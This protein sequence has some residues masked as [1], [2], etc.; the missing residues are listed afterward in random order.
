MPSATFASATNADYAFYY[1]SSVTEIVLSA[2]T[3]ASLTSARAMFNYCGLTTALSIDNATFANLADGWGMFSSTNISSLSMAVA[4]F[5]NLTNIQYW[6]QDSKLVTSL[7]MPLATFAKITDSRFAFT[8]CNAL[9]DINVPNIST[10]I[11]QTSNATNTPIDL[12]FSPLTYQSMLKVANWL[13]DLTGYTAHTCT[14]KATAW[15]ALS[16]AEQ[17]TIDGIL[18]GKNWTRAIA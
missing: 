13:S 6:L 15:N 11:A 4:T 10:A 2:A 12:H 1:T 7:N 16:A 8:R 5:G 14:F 3:F 18:S 17:S 9:Q